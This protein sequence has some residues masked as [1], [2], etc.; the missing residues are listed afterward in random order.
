MDCPLAAMAV[1]GA[2]ES[3]A[4]WYTPPS[5]LTWASNTHAWR[6]ALSPSVLE[7]HS[8]LRDKEHNAHAAGIP[9]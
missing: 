6:I 9:I 2:E 5:T 1:L 4:N 3:P 7:D 8:S